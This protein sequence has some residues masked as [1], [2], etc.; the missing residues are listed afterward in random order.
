MDPLPNP[1]PRLVRRPLR[2]KSK[3]TVPKVRLEQRLDD[4]LD[5]RLH[6]RPG[7]RWSEAGAR[8]ILTLRAHLFSGRLPA[9]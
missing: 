7:A 1:V 8:A 2:P 6:H 3:R 4:D 5:R 9:A